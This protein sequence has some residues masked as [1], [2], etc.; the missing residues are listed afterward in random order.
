MHNYELH[1]SAGERRELELVL[2]IPELALFYSDGSF[3]DL[4]PK[5]LEPYAVWKAGFAWAQF[6]FTGCVPSSSDLIGEDYGN[7]RTL[8]FLR[9]N[10]SYLLSDDIDRASCCAAEIF[11]MLAIIMHIIRTPTLFHAPT[12][13]RYG[14][15]NARRILTGQITYRDPNL[16]SLSNLVKRILRTLN[17]ERRAY[18]E[19][20]LGYSATNGIGANIIHWQWVRA[21]TGKDLGNSWVDCRA[22][23][24]ADSLFTN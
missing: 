5:G 10:G 18:A 1:L 21:H 3:T 23:S 17:E 20:E 4:D 14:S 6:R 9:P 16:V 2:L 12:L 8:N 13:I 22:K 7:V 15:E 24:G 19:L 11:G